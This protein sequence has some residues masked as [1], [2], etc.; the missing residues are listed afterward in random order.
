[1]KAVFIMMDYAADNRRNLIG[2]VD[3]NFKKRLIKFLRSIRGGSLARQRARINAQ[4]RADN[5]N[6]LC[7]NWFVQGVNR[8]D[9]GQ[10]L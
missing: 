1:M 8:F 7:K 2:G 6:N 3:R 5:H 4:L 10:A 9:G